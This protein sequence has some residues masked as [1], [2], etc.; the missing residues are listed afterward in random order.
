MR[1]GNAPSGALQ[2]PLMEKR[3]ELRTGTRFLW[4]SRYGNT[5]HNFINV[6]RQLG[7]CRIKISLTSGAA[8]SGKH[9]VRLALRHI[10][11][12]DTLDLRREAIS[13]LFCSDMCKTL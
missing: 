7:R 4:G 1:P 6:I 13:V 12:I 2:L 3:P 5:Q 8:L 10:L 11:G 9:A